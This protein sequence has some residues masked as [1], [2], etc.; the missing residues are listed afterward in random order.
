MFI[1]LDYS[2]LFMPIVNSHTPPHREIGLLEVWKLCSLFHYGEQS[3]KYLD[4]INN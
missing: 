3:Y 1:L 2:V 4:K